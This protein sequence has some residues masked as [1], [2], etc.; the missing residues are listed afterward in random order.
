MAEGL[1]AVRAPV[2]AGDG[3]DSP[4]VKDGIQ[5][6]HGVRSSWEIVEGMGGGRSGGFRGA[7]RLF[8]NMQVTKSM[9]R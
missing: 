5:G 3:G 9:N 8:Y 4:L 2:S 1:P 7:C 6:D